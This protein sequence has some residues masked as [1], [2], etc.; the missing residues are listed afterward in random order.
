M[1][2]L[3]YVAV[4]SLLLAA[5]PVLAQTPAAAPGAPASD[6]VKI[7]IEKGTKIDAGGMV[8]EQTY[9]ADGSY[10]GATDGDAGKY[11][12]DGKKLC[13]TPDAIGQEICIEY[14]DGKKS[15]E[16][17]EAQSD[18]GPMTVSIK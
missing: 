13:L 6:T 16:S 10:T 18:F 14:P 5:V 12:A 4:A 15:G 1:Q 8:Y 2:A 7:A 17:F 11:R 9:K 3:K